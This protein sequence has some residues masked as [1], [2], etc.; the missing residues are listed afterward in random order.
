MSVV[1]DFVILLK[2]FI[3]DVEREKYKSG[4]SSGTFILPSRGA[5]IGSIPR[6]SGWN[7]TSFGEFQRNTSCLRVK[8][9]LF[10]IFL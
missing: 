9:P 5:N 8:E 2:L 1:Y 3:S 4:A 6:P 7:S 10:L